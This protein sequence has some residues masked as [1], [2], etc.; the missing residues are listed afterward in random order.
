MHSIFYRVVDEIHY[1]GSSD[2]N[3][4]RSFSNAVRDVGR[5]LERPGDMLPDLL[6]DAENTYDGVWSWEDGPNVDIVIYREELSD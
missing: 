1:E 5:R 4:Y 6:N 3:Y 2:P